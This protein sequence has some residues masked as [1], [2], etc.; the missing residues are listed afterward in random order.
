MKKKSVLVFLQ[1]YLPGNLSGGPV[2]SIANMVETLGDAVDFRVVCSDRD[3]GQATA[4]PDVRIGSWQQVGKAQAIYLSAPATRLRHLRRLLGNEAVDMVYF[5][6]FFNPRFTIFPLWS[7]RYGLLPAWKVLIAPRGE[8]SPG[9]LKFSAQK[10]KAYLCAALGSGV[11]KDV[12]WHASTHFEAEDIKRVTGAT[13]ERITI[14]PD[15]PGGSS[16]ETAQEAKA[17]GVL[18]VVALSRVVPQKNLAEAIRIVCQLEGDIAFDIYGLQEDAA[19]LEE[20]KDVIRSAPGNVSINF[21]GPIAHDAVAAQLARYHVFLLPTNSENFGHAIYE[22]M[23]SGLPV[24][25]SD[26]TP[27]R[28]LDSHGAGYD[29]DLNDKAAFVAALTR[30][31]RMSAVEF[32][33]HRQNSRRFAQDWIR[34]SGVMELNRRLFSDVMHAAV[35]ATVEEPA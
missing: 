1:H 22:A 15:L 35:G 19:Y 16:Q 25:I 18:R 23:N 2:R 13:D 31:A 6:S 32:E 28:N 26:R 14:A 10:K 17:P 27:W 33:L 12:Q 3:L 11:L 8:F 29:L 4:Y 21:M 34:S 30:Y 24:V 7:V 20:C 9:A 5:N